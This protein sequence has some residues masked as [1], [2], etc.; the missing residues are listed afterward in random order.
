[1]FPTEPTKTVDHYH[2]GAWPAGLSA[3]NGETG[4]FPFAMASAIWF[5]AG[6]WQA[7]AIPDLG[8]IRRRA[9]SSRAFSSSG[10]NQGQPQMG[11]HAVPRTQVERDRGPAHHRVGQVQLGLSPSRTSVSPS[12]FSRT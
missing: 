11:V 2:H 12:S 1:M 5:V 7:Q 10:F 3:F 4:R 6:L 8:S 9:A